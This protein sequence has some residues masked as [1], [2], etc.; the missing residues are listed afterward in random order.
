MPPTHSSSPHK[1]SVCSFNK[2]SGLKQSS[3]V[4]RR[5]LE[6]LGPVTPP[7][8]VLACM[9]ALIE[10]GVTLLLFLQKHH[11][12]R[13]MLLAPWGAGL[14]LQVPHAQTSWVLSLGI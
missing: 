7:L 12:F 1:A 13:G 2:Y 10:D 14:S 11:V 9:P 4:R 5:V 8:H 6:A 3:T